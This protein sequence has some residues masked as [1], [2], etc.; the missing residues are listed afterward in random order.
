MLRHQ[1]RDSN[2]VYYDCQQRFKQKIWEIKRNHWR[3]FLAEKGPYHAYQAYRFTKNRQEDEITLLRSREGNL[4]L[5]VTEK[6]SLLFHGTSVVEATVDLGDI[7]RNQLPTLTLSFP[8]ITKDEIEKTIL[9]LPNKKALEL[10]GIYNKLIKLSKPLLNMHL[11]Y[12]YNL[13]LKQ[14]RYPSIWKEACMA[15]IS[16]A[17]KADYTDPNFY[18]PIALLDTLRKLFEKIINK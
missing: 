15:I 14:G 7:P 1:S 13:C 16:K 18:R 8:L 17:A 3:R 2:R 5:Y 10:D 12:L 11:L 4:T 9:E 6:S